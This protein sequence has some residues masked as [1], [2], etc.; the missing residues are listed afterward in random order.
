MKK[1]HV[2]YR[3]KMDGDCCTVWTYAS[4]EEDAVQIIEHEYWDVDS[5]IEVY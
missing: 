5:I 2:V 3:S 1:Y 4:N